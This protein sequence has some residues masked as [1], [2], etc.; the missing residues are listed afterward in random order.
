MSF[1]ATEGFCPMHTERKKL[2]REFKVTVVIEEVAA[3][4]IAET[5]STTED[6]SAETE[7]FFDEG[8]YPRSP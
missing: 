2:T 4:S 3:P 5:P 1:L 8:D 7:E 6:W